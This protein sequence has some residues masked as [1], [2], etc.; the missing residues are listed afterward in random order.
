MLFV[1]LFPFFFLLIFNSCNN[2][3]QYSNDKSEIPDLWYRQAEIDIGRRIII[4]SPNEGIAISNGRGDIPGKA[5]KLSNGKWIP[6]HQYPYSDF[7][8]ISQIDTSTIWTINHLT[9]RGLYKPV[10]NQFKNGI[11]TELNLPTI[12][13]DSIDYAMWK[14]IYVLGPENIR[15]VGQQGNIL[16]Y[17]GENWSEELSPVDKSKLESLIS[18]DI[19]DIFMLND[20][21]GWAC[22]KD[23]LII[24][25]EKGKWSKVNSPTLNHLEK[26]WMTNENKGWIVGY[27]GTIL[28]FNGKTWEKVKVNSA[29]NLF[30]VKGI[31]EN[32]IF[33]VGTRSTLIYY[34]GNN[35]TADKSVRTIEDNFYDIDIITENNKKLIWIIGFNGIYTNSQTGGVSF[36]DVTS[37]SAIRQ[38]GKKGLFFTDKNENNTNLFVINSDAPPVFNKNIGFGR[39]TEIPIE[40]NLETETFGSSVAT[41]ADFNN[42]GFSDVLEIGLGQSGNLLLGNN[43]SFFDFTQKANIS[44][45]FNIEAEIIGVQAADFD[46][47]GNLD[48]IF[49]FLESSPFILKNNGASQFTKVNIPILEYGRNKSYGFTIADFNNDL[50]PDIFLTFATPLNNYKYHLY[51]NKG[52][53]NFELHLDSTFYVTQGISTQSTISI[54]EDFNNDGL[55]D[56]FIH[57]LK[58]APQLLINKGNLEF[59]DYSEQYGFR[60][61]IFHNDPSSGFIAAGDVNNDGWIDL[62]IGSKLLLNS[63]ENYFEDVTEQTG[64]NFSGNP[65]FGDI[66]NDGDLDLYIG[67]SQNVFGK[68]ARS[69]LYRNNINN[70]NFAKFKLIGDKSNRGAIGSSIYLIAN[71]KNGNEVYR[72]LRQTGLG[73][74]TFNNQ[75]YSDIHFGLSDTLNYSAEIHFPSGIIKTIDKIEKGYTSVVYESSFFVHYYKIIL[76]SISRTVILADYFIETIKISLFVL[77]LIIISI[78]Y[79][80]KI[81]NNKVLFLIL[82]P[83]MISLYFLIVHF[84]ILDDKTINIS[85]PLI[86]TFVLAFSFI[87]VYENIIKRKESKI[88]SHYELINLIGEGGMGKVYKAIDIT[89]KNIVALKVLNPDLVTDVENRKRLTNEGQILSQFNNKNIVKVY[90]IGESKDNVFI[91]MEFLQGGTLHEY[92]KKNHSLSF[93]QIK[94]ISLE[95]C[96]GLKAVHDKDI[97]HRDFKTNNIMLDEN[98]NIRIMDFGLSKSS[99]LT[100]LTSKGTLLGTLGYISPEQ[101]TNTN[102]DKRS[103]IFSLGVIIYELCTNTIP[104][105]GENEIALIH[106]IFNTIPPQPSTIN[107]KIPTQFDYIVQKCLEKN[108]N[109]RFSSVEEIIVLLDNIN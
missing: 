42:D 35:W 53:F 58:E 17:N 88:I 91:S 11:N 30:S 61:I 68:E 63:S 28:E 55:T 105:K 92:V 10:L 98:N 48:L 90:E 9:H 71:D 12:K 23:G 2:K 81:K 49:S 77:I 87:Y 104:F 108:I 16:F 46:N 33:V 93:E 57:Q 20:S 84:T 94:K 76:N 51:I 52:N 103:D 70:S 15:L 82:I 66:D 19:N 107:N 101:I 3:I 25:Y 8:I 65:S 5:Y 56:L 73:S 31:D 74:A 80:N 34:D 4:N 44:E 18:G 37:Q 78:V 83:L 109:E 40:L 21:I 69:I 79:K 89:N 75:I 95:I 96:N 59:E 47:D 106:S 43:N 85:L 54:A 7:S 102:V 97:V 24:K 27:R 99:L 39:F 36:S 32:N 100:K 6:F 22:G 62:F 13:W 29:E 50:L 67:N 41:I 60:E 1:I 26:V 72:T 64:I 45:Y 38:T 86:S 14:G